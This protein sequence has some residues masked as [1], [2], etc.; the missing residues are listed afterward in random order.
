MSNRKQIPVCSRISESKGCLGTPADEANATIKTI[1]RYY[2]V[3]H[4]FSSAKPAVT[5]M[6]P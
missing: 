6:L 3:I 2:D 4:K 5:A 1:T